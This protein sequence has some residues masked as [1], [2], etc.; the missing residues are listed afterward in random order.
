MTILPAPRPSAFADSLSSLPPLRRDEIEA[1]INYVDE[2]VDNALCLINGLGNIRWQPVKQKADVVISRAADDIN[3]LSNQAAVRTVCTVNASF[4][5]MM[6]HFITET[7]EMFRERETALHGSE[8][9]DGAVLHVLHPRDISSE[10]TS[11]RFVCIKW[12]CLKAV[13]SPT[14]PRDY[15]YI[16]L[17]DS[18]VDDQNVRVGIRLSKSIDLFNFPSFEDS[19]RFVRAKT[20]NMH[21]FHSLDSTNSSSR[22]SILSN[23]SSSSSPL[24]SFQVELRSMV[25]G[26]PNGRLPAWVVTKM[27]DLAALRGQSIRDFFEQQRLSTLQWVAPH[28]YVPASKRSFCGICTRGFSLVRKKYNC[29]ACGEVVCNQCS[30]VQLIGPKRTKTRVCI[31]CNIQARSTALHTPNNS[32]LASRPSSAGSLHSPHNNSITSRQTNHNRGSLSSSIRASDNGSFLHSQSTPDWPHPHPQPSSSN[33]HPT[34]HVPV[35][36]YRRSQSEMYDPSH[37]HGSFGPTT[38]LSASH[39]YNRDSNGRISDNQRFTSSTTRTSVASNASTRPSTTTIQDTSTEGDRTL[40]PFVTVITHMCVC[41]EQLGPPPREGLDLGVSH[42]KQQ[43]VA[44]SVDVVSLGLLALHD[45]SIVQ[46]PEATNQPH[47]LGRVSEALSDMTVRNSEMSERMSEL[48][49]DAYDDD[50]YHRHEGAVVVETTNN[51]DLSDLSSF[52][53]PSC[54][55]VVHAVSTVPDDEVEEDEE[56]VD[57]RWAY[58]PSHMAAEDYLEATRMTLAEIDRGMSSVQASMHVTAVKL[59]EQEQDQMTRISMEYVA[60][61]TRTTSSSAMDTM[62]DVENLFVVLKLNAEIDRLQHKMETVQEGTIQL[63]HMNEAMNEK[64]QTLEKVESK[65]T[66][67]PAA[68]PEQ[69]DQTLLDAMDRI[70]ENFKQLQHQMDRVQVTSTKVMDVKL[71]EG[72]THDD[73]PPPCPP[74]LAASSSEESSPPPFPESTRGGFVS[75]LED[76]SFTPATSTGADD[77]HPEGW[78]S[79][80]SKLPR[81]EFKADEALHTREPFGMSFHASDTKVRKSLAPPSAYKLTSPST[82]MTPTPSPSSLAPLSGSRVSLQ[83][84]A[85][86]RWLRPRSHQRIVIRLHDIRTIHKCTV[87]VHTCR[88]DAS[89]MEQPEYAIST[90][91]VFACRQYPHMAFQSSWTTWRSFDEFRVLDYQLR[92]IPMHKASTPKTTP[93]DVV[94]ESTA[95]A[96]SLPLFSWWRKSTP[97]STGTKDVVEQHPMVAIAPLPLHRR[98]R[99]LFQHKTK[100]FMVQRQGELEAYLQAVCATSLRLLHFLDIHAPPYMRYFCNFDAGFGTQLHVTVWN[101]SLGAVET[102]KLDVLESHLLDDASRG[103]LL[104]STYGCKCHFQSLVDGHRNMQ[105]YLTSKHLQIV[106]WDLPGIPED[107]DTSCDVRTAYLCLVQELYTIEDMELELA[108]LERLDKLRHKG[109]IHRMPATA[110]AEKLRRYMTNY[111][112]LHAEAIASHVGM[113]VID[114][115]KAFHVA[116][117]PTQ[118]RVGALALQTLA[119]MLNLTIILVTNDHRHTV[120]T[121]VPWKSPPPLVDGPP[122]H[123]MWSYLLPTSQYIHGHYRILRSLAPLSSQMQPKMSQQDWMVMDK[124]FVR[125]MAHVVENNV[126]TVV[127]SEDMTAEVLQQAIL[128]AVWLACEQNPKRFQRFQWT[129]KQYGT[130]RMPGATFFAFLE[131]LFRPTGAAYISDFL[132]HVLPLPKKRQALVRAR[133]NRFHSELMI[134]RASQLHLAAR[135]IKV[136]PTHTL[137]MTGIHQRLVLVAWL[138]LAVVAQG[139]RVAIFLDERESADLNSFGSY[140][141]HLQARGHHLAI[142]NQ[143]SSNITLAKYGV[144]QYDNIVILAPSLK[145]LGTNSLQQDAL[146]SFVEQGGNVLVAGSMQVSTMLRQ[147]A[148]A[149]GVQF[150]KKGTVVMD[151]VRHVGDK[152]DIYHSHLTSQQW[153]QFPLVVGRP[154]KPIFFNGVGMSVDPSNVLALTVL[155]A[156]P[157]S[158]SASPTKRPIDRAS[159]NFGTNVSLVAA[160]QARNNAR[161]VFSG[162]VDLFKDAYYSSSYGNGDFV[163]AV[164]KWT[165]GERGV[166]RVTNVRHT[167]EDGTPPDA[168]LRPIDRP[169]QPLTLYPDAEVARNSLVYRIKDNVTYSFDVH[170]RQDD[171]TWTPFAADDMQLE[172]VMLDPYVRKTLAHDDR[173]HFAVTFATPDVYGIFQFR[174]MYRRVGY[175]VLHWTTQVSVRPYKH[176]EYDRFLPAA[177]PY[178]ASVFSMMTGVFLFSVLFL[179]GQD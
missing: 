174:V 137:K 22:A 68:A 25:L 20:F 74:L 106:P 48:D 98:K 70:N 135:R 34:L 67:D 39:H 17:V 161:V 149:L 179:Y 16:E 75:F 64:I 134:K 95:P 21:T 14:K 41:I 99:W 1:Y 65:K 93:L 88:F 125:S 2:A 26:D 35:A 50:Q 138:L 177:Y 43:S 58:R 3:S 40:L 82:D 176:D 168:M 78:T 103:I 28:H 158:Y 145:T 130:S 120:R 155:A 91:M 12:H 128:D 69:P 112:I 53:D 73:P 116:K 79:V 148:A 100:S 129:S 18:F 51:S 124:R 71:V 175:S 29:Q 81:Q 36:A 101:P 31:G 80:H 11:Q 154:S 170:E 171:G 60:P 4:D 164:T 87:H 56:D 90:E 19:H 9:L 89:I 5:E 108:S 105:A 169:D 178:Y 6:D 59:E 54:V 152:T 96:T 24:S 30:L 153:T 140:I 38:P 33:H 133:W 110:A 147:F 156:E 104:C 146:L 46:Q 13:A 113:N 32:S 143:A 117:K 109:A 126:I 115:K 157:T 10:Y 162:S 166:L 84:T 49:V 122:R 132:V 76:S 57:A 123:L 141:S 61:P 131:E 102:D 47:D 42:F 72:L 160:I 142:F 66:T 111:G 144:R 127:D 85:A 55:H 62:P 86:T 173:G 163:E 45:L 159:S 15:V 27:S 23:G 118:V 150:D 119:T 97:T 94:V 8:F 121:V 37:R 172:F 114:V 52:M 139:S 151:H 83:R 165:F 77:A 136:P 44:S 167:K 7:T 63:N 107:D 92:Q